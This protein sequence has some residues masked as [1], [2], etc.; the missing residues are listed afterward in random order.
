M[1]FLPT[2]WALQCRTHIID[3]QHM[4][5]RIQIHVVTEMQPKLVSG[6]YFLVS[7]YNPIGLIVGCQV[8]N[9]K[10]YYNL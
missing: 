2:V 7:I 10:S 9:A 8:S 3:P 6:M 4:Y 1:T 5:A